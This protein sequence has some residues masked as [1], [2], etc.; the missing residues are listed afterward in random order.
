MNS[1]IFVHTLSTAAT[2]GFEQEVYTGSESS[3]EILVSIGVLQGELSDPV[4]VRMYTM[5]GS[6]LSSRDY[7]SLNTTFTLS[8]DVL[9]VNVSVKVMD[10]KIDENRESLLARLRLEP[11]DEDQNVQIQPDEATL[12]IIDNDGALIILYYCEW[13]S[14]FV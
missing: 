7:E 8:P 11:A 1:M 14:N 9:S 2:I 6:A 5:D 10:D 12:F 13:E 3:G 4:V